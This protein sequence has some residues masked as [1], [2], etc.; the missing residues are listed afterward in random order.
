MLLMDNAVFLE[1]ATSGR[2]FKEIQGK[3]SKELEN[4]VKGKNLSEAEEVK[5]AQKLGL[6]KTMKHPILYARVHLAGALPMLV[7][8]GSSEFWRLL[9]RDPSGIHV[10]STFL[11]RGPLGVIA[12]LISEKSFSQ[13]CY[14]AGAMIF[15]FIIYIALIVGLIG[16]TVNRKYSVAIL[17]LAILGYFVLTVGPMGNMRFRVPI[18]PYTMLLAAYGFTRFSRAGH[19]VRRFRDPAERKA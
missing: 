13:I 12:S 10:L 2:S 18:M 17:F 15:L 14:I 7:E 6:E 9:G 4:L 5:V 16:L 11:T 8:P 19:W 1:Q 3:F